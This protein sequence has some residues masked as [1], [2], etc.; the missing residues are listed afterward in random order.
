MTL[1]TGR[2]R[3]L[4]YVVREEFKNLDLRLATGLALAGMLPQPVGHRLRTRLLRMAGVEIGRTTVVLGR[5]RMTGSRQAGSNVRIGELCV[6]NFGCIF[7]AAAPIVIGDRVGLG[8]EVVILT[9]GHV[10]G[11]PA[12]RLGPLAARGVTIGDGAWVSTRAIVLPGVEIGEGA[13]VAAGAV[14]TRS[15][16][17]HRLVGGVP[18]RVIRHLGAAGQG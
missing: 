15:V 7:D 4:R 10:V 3:H 11:P 9:N 13:V 16:P 1:P 18:A 5:I 14:V 2:R 12:Q 6:I 17:P 8:Q